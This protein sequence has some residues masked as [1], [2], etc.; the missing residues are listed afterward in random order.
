MVD[1]NN[2]EN[3]ANVNSYLIDVSNAYVSEN[4]I[5]LLN[6]KYEGSYGVPPI[7]SLFGLAGAIGPFIYEDEED[8]GYYTQIYKFDF[9]DNGT[10][11]Y[12]CKNKVKGKTIN[13]YSVDEYNNTLR[14]A[15]YDSDG[16]RVVVFDEKF[17]KT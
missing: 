5:Y 11:E 7:K 12:S 2:I 1:L 14:L 16:S 9:K 8:S 6:Q 17:N 3:D 15:V 10:I 4:S 13:Q